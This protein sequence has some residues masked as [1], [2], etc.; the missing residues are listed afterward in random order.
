MYGNSP[1]SP[2]YY[3]FF[4]NWSFEKNFHGLLLTVIYCGILFAEK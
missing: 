1:P 3:G 4:Q 2:E